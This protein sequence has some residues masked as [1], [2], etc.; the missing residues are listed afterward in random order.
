M[1]MRKI[2]IVFLMFAAAF[3]FAFAD[4]GEEAP[5]S[6]A[7][8]APVMQAEPQQQQPAKAVKEAILKTVDPDQ[9]V[10]KVADILPSDLTR[11][12]SKLI[13]ADENGNETEF[14]VK[15]LAVIYSENGTM[16]ALSELQKGAEVQVNY[17][18]IKDKVKEATSIKIIK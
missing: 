15:T 9:M 12:K 7:V 14:S 4:E 8:A 2:T 1:Y 5:A 16:M 6:P 17:R 11:P 3:S 13:V 18:T 10:G